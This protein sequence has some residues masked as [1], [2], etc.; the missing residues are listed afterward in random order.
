MTQNF[1]NIQV[2]QDAVQFHK[3]IISILPKFPKEEIYA[4]SSQLRRASLSISNNIAEGCGRETSKELRNFLNIAMGSTKEVESMILVSKELD[5]INNE[6]FMGLI[7]EIII[8][9]KKLNSLM[10]RVT[11][12]I[13]KKNNKNSQI[14]RSPKNQKPKTKNQQREAKASLPQTWA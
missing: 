11:E 12:Q 4:M 9:G 3:T 10:Q 5:Y 8:I 2:W 14:G 13:P 6:T 7:Q 1:Q